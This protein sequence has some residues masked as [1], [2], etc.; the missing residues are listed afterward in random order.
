M[1]AE[2]LDRLPYIER[3]SFFGAFRSSVSNV[4]T[5]ATM[6]S[7]GGSLTDIGRWYLGR[8]GDGMDPDS[9]GSESQAPMLRSAI[10]SSLVL[11]FLV[12][13]LVV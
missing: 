10:M 6:L 9:T 8:A 2:Y 13:I 5:N 3:Y 11:A 1:S 7:A 4:G 12:L